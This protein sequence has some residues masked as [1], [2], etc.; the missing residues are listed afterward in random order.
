MLNPAIDASYTKFFYRDRLFLLFFI[1][2]CALHFLIWALLFVFFDTF[3]PPDTD[4]IALHAA[5][6]VG[7]DYIA[8]WES[9]FLLPALGGFL[10]VC[11]TLLAGALIHT[12][13]RLSRALSLTALCGNGVLV[14]A[15]YLLY[16]INL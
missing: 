3:R 4:Y 14:Y 12:N 13:K 15:L 7:T 8:R 16:R 9:I 6:I 11:N 5:V 2:A 1:G 10:I